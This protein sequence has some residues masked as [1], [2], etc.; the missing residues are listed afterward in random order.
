MDLLQRFA[1]GFFW[2]LLGLVA[3]RLFSLITAV[4]IAR[5]LGKEVFGELGMIQ[6]TI[7]LLGTFAG[8]GLGLTTTKYVAELKANAPD[9]AGRIIALSNLAALVTGGLM[10]LVCLSLAPFL[11]RKTMNAPHLALMLQVGAPILLVSALLGVQTGSLFGFQAFRA[12]AR[13]NFWQ[14]LFTLPITLILVYFL[15]LLGAV[16]SLIA[17][18]LAGVVFSSL[19]LRNE[20]AASALRVSYRDSWAERRVLWD[21]SLPA[22]LSGSMVSQVTWAANAILVNQPNG[23]AELGLFNAANQFRMFIM[24]LPNIIGM[25]TLPLLSEIHGQNEGS[26][27]RAINANL[28]TIWGLSLPLGS[29]LIG[30]SPWLMALYGTQ[31]Q[32]GH[33]I[34]ALLVCVTIMH[35]AGST[36][37]QALISSGKIWVGFSL[38]MAWALVLLPTVV[39]LVPSKGAM[40]LALAYFLA[41]FFLTICLLLF[42]WRSLGRSSVQYSFVLSGLTG[43]LFLLAFGSGHISQILAAVLALFTAIITGLYGWHVLPLQGKQKVLEI[44]CSG[45]S[46]PEIT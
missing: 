25:V 10:T 30:L 5:L 15:G 26:F 33:L 4:V 3:T 19:T 43:I 7:G 12:I 42:V 44:F 32:E 8:F 17:S 28:R 18:A 24:F 13:I 14:G 2:S 37:G 36:V 45:R 27:V 11:A 35:V 46:V 39:F 41:Y 16:L 29:L 21:F 40:G 20:C 34:L 1:Q 22:V 31:F 23:Y 6:S 9:R 38:N